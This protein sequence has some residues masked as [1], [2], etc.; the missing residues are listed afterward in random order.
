MGAGCPIFP[1][2]SIFR[3]NASISKPMASTIYDFRFLTNLIQIG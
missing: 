3:Q 1:F 2:F